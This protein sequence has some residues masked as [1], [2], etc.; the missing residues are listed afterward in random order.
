MIKLYTNTRFLSE[1]Y[2]KYIFPLLFDLY[3]EKDEIVSQYYKLVDAISDCDI[4]VFPIDYVKFLKFKNEFLEIQSLAKRYNKTIWIYSAGDYG[5]TNYIRNSCTFRL[6]GFNS[7]LNNTTYILPPFISDPY[8]DYLPQG[9]SMLEKTEKPSI[10][11]VGHAQSGLSKY[12]KELTNYFKLLV[13]K[14]FN[15]LIV[16]S[17]KFYP[18]SIKR[19]MYLSK[20][21]MSVKLNTNFILR[22]NY[23]AGAQTPIDIEKTTK[24]FY[25]NIFDNI[26]TFCSRGVG[27]FSVRFYQTLAVGRIPILLDTDCRLPLSNKINWDQHCVI[28]NE[29]K[30]ES[31]EAQILNFHNTKT[32]TELELIQKQNRE[33]WKNYLNRQTFFLQIHNDFITKTNLDKY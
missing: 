16:D 21:D 19:A 26:Y 7:K 10:G 18:S 3:F 5:F 9:F 6:G 32:K 12:V 24:E 22:K 25:N 1:N 4:V 2:R 13:K 15:V 33:L 28:L 20:L 27:N 17:Q 8:L 31:L 29:S 23:R 11:F 30:E 14:T